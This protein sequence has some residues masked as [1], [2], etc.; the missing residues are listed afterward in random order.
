MKIIATIVHARV[1]NEY[2]PG[3]CQVHV[4]YLDMEPNG[5]TVRAAREE[6]LPADRGVTLEEARTI[7][8]AVVS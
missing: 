4:Q 3:M 6:R 7:R 1:G 5:V 2:V 8:D